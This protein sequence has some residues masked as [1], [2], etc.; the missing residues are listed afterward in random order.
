MR[1][2]CEQLYSYNF[3]TLDEIDKFLEKNKLLMLIKKK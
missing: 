2:H 3:D 1:E